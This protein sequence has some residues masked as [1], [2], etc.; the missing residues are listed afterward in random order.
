MRTT[1]DI[2]DDVMSATRHIA[3]RRRTSIGA[4]LSEL[5]RTGLN[6]AMDQPRGDDGFPGLPKRGLS[7]PITMEFVN[8][9][10]EELDC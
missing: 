8:Q 3:A 4:V 6:G 5:A 7:Q 2:D 10:R 9:L 1:V